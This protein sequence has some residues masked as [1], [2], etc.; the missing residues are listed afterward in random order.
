VAVEPENPSKMPELVQGLRLLNQA[1]PCVEVV[2][3]STGEHILMTAG[4]LHLERCIKDLR[5]RFAKIDIRVSPPIVPFRETIV[6]PPVADPEALAKS[7]QPILFEA[8]GGRIRMQMRAR[9]LPKRV[10]E[11]LREN[12]QV[13]G[14]L[15][16]V[17]DGRTL[18][19]STDQ[20]STA[21]LTQQMEQLQVASEDM[22]ATTLADVDERT[23]S[24]K[25]R[26]AVQKLMD[27]LRK[28]FSKEKDADVW[29]DVLDNLWTFGPKRVGP[30]ILVNRVPGFQRASPF[31]QVLYGKSPLPATSDVQHLLSMFDKNIT[32]GFQLATHAGPLCAEP[33]VGVCW[34]LESFEITM[35]EVKQDDEDAARIASLSRF[36]GQVITSTRDAC[37]KAMLQWS[38]RL[39]LATY[40]CDIQATSEILGRVYGVVARRRGRIVA[41]EMDEST[42]M[43]CIQAKLPVIESFGFADEIRKRT[44]G[45][46]IPQLIFSGYEIL[47]EDP[48]WV[49]STEEEL[50]DLGEKADREN[51][52]R[53]YMDAVRKRKGMFV[54]KKII[55]HAEKQRTLKK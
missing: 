2:V 22:Q 34:F 6:A 14:I 16:G 41:E 38:P 32:A 11:I 54:E 30:N 29:S 21:A 9:P 3:Q 20:D 24:D 19:Q 23:L 42:A 7:K 12:R 28:A 46:A 37:R 55:E 36:A 40:S 49:P 8:A 50:E 26:Q 33:C 10:V 44:S 39:M 48:F 5:E 15:Q 17:V 31:Q 45:A 51:V 1:D 35:D 4:E 27:D 25:G 47:D 43:F 53:R 18:D 52:A 13:I